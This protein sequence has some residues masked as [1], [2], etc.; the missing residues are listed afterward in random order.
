[1]FTRER[2]ITPQI[3]GRLRSAAIEHRI[4]ICGRLARIVSADDA[5]MLDC[6]RGR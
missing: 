6:D 3:I 5:G 4:R 1:V 2:Q